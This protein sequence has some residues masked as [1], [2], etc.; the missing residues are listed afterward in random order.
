VGLAMTPVRDMVMLD[1]FNTRSLAFQVV[2]LQAHLAALPSLVDDGML[3]A[4]DRI[5]VVLATEVETADAATITA[6]H[7]LDFGDALMRLSSAIAD[8]YF[9]QGANAMPTVKLGGLA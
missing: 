8:R 7:M 3:E 9:L 2:T 1:P 6:E 5:V 4:P